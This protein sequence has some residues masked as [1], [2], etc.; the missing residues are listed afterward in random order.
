VNYVSAALLIAVFVST[1]I[2]WRQGR[3]SR[4]HATIGTLALVGVIAALVVGRIRLRIDSVGPLDAMLL[5]VTVALLA[6]STGLSD[7]V[8]RRVRV[9]LRGAERDY[10]LTLYRLVRPLDRTIRAYPGRA[11]EDTYSRWRRRVETVTPR[12]LER[13]ARLDPPSDDWAVV[14]RG[15]IDLYALVL[16][17]VHTGGGTEHDREEIERIREATVTAHTRLQAAY[18]RHDG[19]RSGRPH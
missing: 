7:P 15:Y 10:D 1:V 4:W 19:E 17:Q 13:L 8:V 5:V 11:D 16:R 2:A 6:D 18:A 3:A 14:T 9:A 12:V